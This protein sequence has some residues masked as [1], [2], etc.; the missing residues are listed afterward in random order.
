MKILIGNTAA[1][2]RKPLAGILAFIMSTCIALPALAAPGDHSARPHINEANPVNRPTELPLEYLSIAGSAFHPLATTTAYSYPGAGCIAKTGGTENRFVH[3]AILPE[4]AV[5]RYLRLY[6]YNT[7]SKNIL[8][9]FT[10]YDGRGNYN[11]RTSVSSADGPNGYGS[12]L[13]PDID[14]TI[15][16]HNHAINVLVNLG[17]HNDETLQFCGVRIAYNRHASDQIFANG[18]E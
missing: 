18:F 16:P 17:N 6:Y 5:A 8:A 2:C 1:R 13:S 4:G 14:H 11:E 15:D 10:T 9:F 12:T 7:S 3:K